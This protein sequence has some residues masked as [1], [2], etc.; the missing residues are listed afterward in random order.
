MP[1]RLDIKFMKLAKGL[2]LKGLGNTS[3]NPVVGCVIVKGG[4]VVA[5]GYHKKAGLPHAEIEAIR[6]AK[7]KHIDLKGATMYVT[8]EPCSHFGKTPPCTDS[9]I[10]NGIKK[11]VVG[12]RDPNPINNGKG[13]RILRKRG[14]SVRVGVLRKELEDINLPFIKFINTGMPYVTVKIASS[15]DGK[16]ATKSF[17]SK[18]ITG[19]ST[20]HFAKG[21]RGFVDAILVGANTIIRDNPLLT[22]RFRNNPSKQPL[23]VILDERLRVSLNSNIFSDRSLTKTIIATTKKAPL[24]KIKQFSNQRNVE[25][26]FCREKSGFIDL[27]S[28]L[29]KLAARQIMHILVEGGGETIASF[30]REGL[31]DEVYFFI[32]P[33]VIGGRNAPTSVE[34]EGIERMKEAISIRE[35]NLR[36]IG[37]DILIYGR[38][39]KQCLLV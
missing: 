2:A 11:V 36:Q 27:R 7:E 39:E 14:I 29:K 10:E 35:V 16:I 20:R 21:L 31:V 38:I 33:K 17:D 8:L 5:R 4:R 1:D 3:P 12:M 13:I 15:L 23:K 19:E 18:W 34:G 9:I 26:L 37:N 25:L 30:F 24:E 6:E 32:A 22:N 28:L